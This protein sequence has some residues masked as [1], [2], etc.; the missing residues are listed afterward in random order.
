MATILR[1]QQEQLYPDVYKQNPMN[2]GNILL[3][4][5][6]IGSTSATTINPE[7]NHAAQVRPLTIIRDAYRKK[8]AIYAATTYPCFKYLAA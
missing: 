1:G 7:H 8:T 3:N 4:P 2:K 5:Y 6:A